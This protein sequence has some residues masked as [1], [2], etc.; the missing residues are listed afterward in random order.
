MIKTLLV[1]ILFYSF[2]CSEDIKKIDKKINYNKNILK[3]KEKEKNSTHKKVE[4]LAK[5]ITQE[6]DLLNQL[7][8][9]LDVVSN[10]IFLN[11]LKLS[12]SKKEIKQ[13]SI[14]SNTLQKNI[15]KIEEDLVDN[16][17]EKYSLTLSKNMIDK[18]SAQAII[19]KEKF[20]I[21][22]SDTKETILKSNL[23][24]FKLSNE[25]VEQN[26]KQKE[27]ISYIDE[28]EKEKEK[29]L[30][31]KEE[32]EKAVN[33]LKSKHKEYQ[34]E[35]KSI[36]DKQYTLGLLLNK[37]DILKHSELEKEKQRKLK[38]KKRKE[39]LAKLKKAKLKEE[40]KAKNIKIKKPK[41][42]QSKD[43]KMIS[44]QNLQDEI[45]LKVRNLGDSSKGIKIS[46][47]SGLKIAKPLKSFTITK[48]FGKYYDPVYKIKLFNESIS[49][50]SKVKNAKVYA[51]LKGK[52]VYSKKGA[53]ALGN[54]VIL[55]HKNNI[56]TVY[57]QLSQIPKTIKV[58]KWVSKGYVIGRV[59]DTL[60]FQ[61]TKN[62]KYLN[63]EELF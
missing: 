14:K 51:T 55:K 22:F 31:L 8:T 26:K 28:Q 12:K 47:S 4:N 18:N 50:K 24:Y 7:E 10:T 41:K 2:I 43:I 6:E 49:L 58:G 17:I 13:L 63:P 36:I 35:L 54:V 62:N 53:G 52:V 59:N 21:L 44:K 40:K 61:V 16:I 15:K 45:D 27:L 3:L 42:N 46:K 37:L 20:E 29:F 38:E 57:S 48:K 60:V 1:L 9:K 11:K 23:T 19:D 56:H 33:S 34:K 30:S 25:Q 39:K 5:A 32:Q